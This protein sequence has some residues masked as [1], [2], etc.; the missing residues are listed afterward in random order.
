MTG[1]TT[2]TMQS[3]IDNNKQRPEDDAESELHTQHPVHE[4]ISFADAPSDFDR[5]AMD[6]SARS[7]T[8]IPPSSPPLSPHQR[9]Y[10]PPTATE[11]TF[12]MQQDVVEEERD[13]DNNEA[14]FSSML[15]PV[16]EHEDDFSSIL[17]PAPP[18]IHIS[19]DDGRTQGIGRDNEDCDRDDDFNIPNRTMLEEREMHRK[20][21]DVESSF[22][23]EPSAIRVGEGDACLDD[24]YLV[25][26]PAE[27]D[28]ETDGEREAALN[29][30][31]RE[32]KTPSPSPSRSTTRTDMYRPLGP[33]STGQESERG[34]SLF[35]DDEYTENLDATPSTGDTSVNT[36]SLE[37][38][39]SPTAAASARTISR[40]L[41]AAKNRSEDGESRTGRLSASVRSDTH[42]AA[43]EEAREEQEDV[44][45][46]PRRS[47]TSQR[48][49]FSLSR[50]L[51][52]LRRGE[53]TDGDV[54]E[55]GHSGNTPPN[56][57]RTRP[58]FLASRQS[59]HRYSTSSINTDATSSDANTGLD[60]ALQSGGAVPAANELRPPGD[61]RQ[62]R[63]L[64]RST[65]LGS[66][67]SGISGF[68]DETPLERRGF[69]GISESNLHTLD[70]E[71][72]G[73]S[74][75]PNSAGKTVQGDND[76]APMTPKAKAIDTTMLTDTVIAQ[77]VQD[78]QVPS[79]LSRQFRESNLN[80]SPDKRGAPTPGFSRG[81]NMTLKE[82]SSTIDRLSKENFDLKMRIHFLNEALNKRSEEGVKE[83][84]SENVELKSDKLKLQKDNQALRK[85]MRELENQLRDR[86]DGEKGE[87]KDE[88]A[89][90]TE[91][92]RVS[93]EE[94]ELIYLQER[95]E[96]YEIEIEKLRSESIARESEKRRLA[97]MVKSL[98]DGRV[99]E[100][101]AGAREE[102]VSWYSVCVGPWLIVPI[103][104]GHVE[105]H[106]GCR[107]SCTG[108]S[109]G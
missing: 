89:S 87:G 33:E 108:T 16:P 107:D 84:I 59:S 99:V 44:E 13:D 74:S 85:K 31:E 96:T 64:L 34:Q 49:S 94:E 5:F 21:M 35:E 45:A 36:T 86:G 52:S 71:D 68:S 1:I 48:Q 39:S 61:N 63:E 18:T 46:T 43:G 100:S 77:H 55:T 29:Q 57:R 4:E 47:R 19:H 103:T 30:L 66:M 23:P 78:I 15:D 50:S 25:G 17:L 40:A 12:R 73:T 42:S 26:V 81:K 8:S 24:T 62:K 72:T 101:E 22:L 6:S 65:S 104:L 2:R 7:A 92:E 27:K 75:R 91:E 3:P 69:S 98:S 102:R 56:R 82:Q 88:G 93:M 9:S 90:G 80:L 53:T 14:Q 51:S 11:A 105:G 67:A 83:M 58:K 79:A 54:S 37:T 106:A 32:Q 76:T 41:S 60:Y 28:G 95:L 109:R 10:T 97:E 70:E 38:M 20:L